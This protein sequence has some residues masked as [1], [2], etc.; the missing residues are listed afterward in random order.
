MPAIDQRKLGQILIDR[1]LIN[2]SQLEQALEE[3]GV[4]GRFFGEILVARE[5]SRR[6][7]LPEL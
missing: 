3:Q 1:G 5:R 2:A 4:S 7:K 6:K